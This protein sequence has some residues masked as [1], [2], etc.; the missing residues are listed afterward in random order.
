[1]NEMLPWRTGC[2][3]SWALVRPAPK[4]E[5]GRKIIQY[6][7]IRHNTMLYCTILY[8]TVPKQEN[9]RKASDPAK[10]ESMCYLQMFNV[11]KVCQIDE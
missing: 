11:Q 3:L 1:M 10:K 8:Y 4:Q 9:G 5:D 2:P 6:Y 7:T